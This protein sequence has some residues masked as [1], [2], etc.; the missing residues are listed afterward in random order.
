MDFKG[1][2]PLP[3]ELI[4]KGGAD[5]KAIQSYNRQYMENLEE[6][7]PAIP[8]KKKHSKWHIREALIYSVHTCVRIV[9]HVSHA[10]VCVSSYFSFL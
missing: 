9:P 10:N 7:L 8:L 6:G 3:R 4:E 2:L 5:V 1:P